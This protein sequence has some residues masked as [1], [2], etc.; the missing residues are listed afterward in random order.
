MEAVFSPDSD[1]IVT[2]DWKV[3]GLMLGLPDNGLIKIESSNSSQFDCQKSMLRLWMES[4]HAYWSVLVQVM[5]GPVMEQRELAE[6]IRTQQTL[7]KSWR[8]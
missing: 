6:G 1:G 7:S 2:T 8:D 4:R 3:L 5:G